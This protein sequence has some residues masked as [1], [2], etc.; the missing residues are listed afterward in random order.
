MC[1]V[2][3]PSLA[4]L[5]L[6]EFCALIFEAVPGLEPYHAN[7]EEIY[8]AFNSYKRSVPVRG[9][10]LLDPTLTQCLLVRGWRAGDAWGF[11][12]GKLSKGE[13]DAECAVREVG[14]ETGLDIRGRV[15]EEDCIRVRLGAQDICMF[16]VPGVGTDTAFAPTV[17]YEIGAYGWHAVR[18]LPAS[19]DEDRQA[20]QSEQGKRHRFFCVWP[21]VRPLHSWIAR[22][23]GVGGIGSAPG[24]LNHPVF[25]V[26]EQGRSIPN[27]P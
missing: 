6:K 1:R 16:I 21:F 18:D 19:L 24:V 4:S 9:A 11:P 25:S 10:I 7:L 20:F 12:R 3:H 13:T 26:Y 14:E 8:K 23:G 27:H 17:K 15:R 5:S 2:K 22:W